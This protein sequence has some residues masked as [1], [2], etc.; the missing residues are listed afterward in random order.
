M[1]IPECLAALEEQAPRVPWTMH[2]VRDGEVPRYRLRVEGRG[3][4]VQDPLAFLADTDVTE[5]HAAGRLLGLS[6]D[7]ILR[8]MSAAGDFPGQDSR[9]ASAFD[10]PWDW[11]EGDMTTTHYRSTHE[12][13]TDAHG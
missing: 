6:A 9:C 11:R 13:R 4:R 12:G 1:T 3:P 10:R 7:D 8:L 2:P 5:V